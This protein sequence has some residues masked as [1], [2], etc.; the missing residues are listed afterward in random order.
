MS[1]R[2]APL[3]QHIS[4]ESSIHGVNYTLS[5]DSAAAHGDLMCQLDAGLPFLPSTEQS[6]SALGV[7]EGSSPAQGPQTSPSAWYNPP[8][9]KPNKKLLPFTTSHY[10]RYDPALHNIA[11]TAGTFKGSFSI[12]DAYSLVINPTLSIDNIPSPGVR[13]DDYLAGE[14]L[15]SIESAEILH[16]KWPAEFG[17]NGMIR[18]A[19]IPLGHA[20]KMWVKPGDIDIDG[21]VVCPGQE[22][23]Y[24]KWWRGLHCLMGKEG[25]DAGLYWI[26][27]WGEGFKCEGM[28][29]KISYQGASC[30]AVV[31]LA[32]GDPDDPTPG[33]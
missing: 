24:Y 1:E 33:L 27:P 17:Q 8:P 14:L 6:I 22:G 26:R 7:S 20:A 4:H 29:F 9:R 31:Q 23:W 21:N 13:V 10:T 32:T 3:N 25:Y 30:R 18:A 28:T 5:D 12:Y 11:P 2:E 19:R 15:V 16:Q